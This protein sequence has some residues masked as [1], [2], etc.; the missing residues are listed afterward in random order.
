MIN[1][2]CTFIRK[3][4]KI[5]GR[6]E[7]NGRGA[8]DMGSDMDYYQSKNLIELKLNGWRDKGLIE[9]CQA[10]TVQ[11]QYGNGERLMLAFNKDNV[12]NS[13]YYRTFQTGQHSHFG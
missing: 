8:F 11:D 1:S 10:E 3:E 7:H 2:L 13:Y 4:L 12:K 5:K 6:T 9:Y